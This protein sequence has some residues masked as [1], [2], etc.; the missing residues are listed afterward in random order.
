MK[1]LVYSFIFIITI[2]ISF[3][4]NKLQADKTWLVYEN[5]GKTIIEQIIFK[6]D[7]PDFFYQST[8]FKL[9]R[10]IKNEDKSTETTHIY[11]LEGQKG[12]YTFLMGNAIMISRPEISNKITWEVNENLTR[13]NPDGSKSVFKL[14]NVSY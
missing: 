7:D 12:E 11:T 14:I 3:A 5:K 6:P 2:Q 1:V 8:R 10:M 4:Q 9:T 13:I